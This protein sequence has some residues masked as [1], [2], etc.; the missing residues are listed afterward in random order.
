M[1][2]LRRSLALALPALLTVTACGEVTVEG[3]GETTTTITVTDD[4]DREVT[5]QGPVERAV[6]INSYGNEFVRAIGAG[7]TVVGVDRVSLTRLP[8]LPV[9]EEDVVAEGLDQLNYEAITQLDPDVVILPRNAVWQEA[10]EQL[11]AFDIPV[12]VATA[13]DAH[14]VDETITLL[15]EVF[16]EQEGADEVLAFQNEIDALLEER[17]AGVEPLPVYLETVDPYLTVL[18]GSGFHDMI[19]DAGGR[20]IFEDASGGDAQEELTVDPVEVVLREPALIFHEFEPGAEPNDRFADI[21]EDLATRQGWGGLEAVQQD[22]LA[23]ANGWATSA[24]GK[25]IGAVYLASWLHPE[26]MEG[27]DPD[28]YLERWVTQFQD[29]EFTSADDYVQ[30]PGA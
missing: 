23:V 16:G 30:G 28:A 9:D 6:V 26:Q 21:R 18:P 22:R 4:Q 1:T 14:A 8:Y 15:G 19:E 25:A 3:A 12:V 24:L 2:T 7:D 10:T 17:L 20:N 5:I 11:E 29:T 13:W 27:V